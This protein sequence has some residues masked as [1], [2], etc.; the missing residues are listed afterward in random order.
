M[1]DN[2][3]QGNEKIEEAIAALQQEPTQEMLAHTLTVIRRR[4]Q[5]KGQFVIAV[6]P[7]T[8]DNQLKLQAITTD[9]G[10]VWWMAFTSFEEELKGSNSVMS[11]FMTDI[12]QLFTSALQA[13]AISGI[14]LN[15]WNRT[16]MLDKNLIQITL[17]L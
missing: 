4:M 1:K 11:T 5:E 14:I 2:E 17:G 9:D 16:I 15:P 7:P 8:G 10:K 13:D 12:K 6:E 3:L